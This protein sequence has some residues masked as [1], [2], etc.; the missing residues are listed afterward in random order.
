MLILLLPLLIMGKNKNTK[1]TSIDTINKLVSIIAGLIV[2]VSVIIGGNYWFEKTYASKTEFNQLKIQSKMLE[3]K[4][5]CY[6]YEKILEE[7]N[8]QKHMH[9]QNGDAKEIL[10]VQYQEEKIQRELLIKHKLKN[11]LFKELLV[12]IK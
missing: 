4:L 8:K 12:P 11:D 5:D 7:L 9:T 10:N 3:L 6:R 1:E 2:T